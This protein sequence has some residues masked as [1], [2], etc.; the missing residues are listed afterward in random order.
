MIIADHGLYVLGKTGRKKIGV[1]Q[2][3]LKDGFKWVL[4]ADYYNHRYINSK[5]ELYYF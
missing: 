4:V 5:E 2:P 3:S 1:A